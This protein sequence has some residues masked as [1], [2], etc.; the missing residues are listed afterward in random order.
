[1]SALR[2]GK[3]SRAGEG[4]VQVHGFVGV[5]YRGLR[6]GFLTCLVLLCLV[7]FGGDFF[8]KDNVSSR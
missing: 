3:C 4:H 7:H 1:M 2:L 8:L 6:G 5:C